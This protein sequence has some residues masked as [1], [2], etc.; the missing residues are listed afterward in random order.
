[1]AAGYA[2]S[3]AVSLPADAETYGSIWWIRDEAMPAA[4]ADRLI[5]YVEAGGS[6]L[7]TGEMFFA[8]EWNDAI[9]PMI[10]A[11]VINQQ[12]VVGSLDVP[13][14]VQGS[15]CDISASVVGGIATQPNILTGWA[16][17]GPGVLTGVSA[18]NVLAVGVPVSGIGPLPVIAA[19]WDSPQLRGPGRL[20]VLMDIDWMNVIDDR[21]TPWNEPFM[22][23]L[24]AFLARH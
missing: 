13:Y 1:M 10:S 5:A 20:V 15:R 24:A 6:V 22:E 2:V 11:L 16:P 9:Q 18:E 8:Q 21:F 3:Q 12:I 19:A 23:N 14:C 7:L 4:D 17:I